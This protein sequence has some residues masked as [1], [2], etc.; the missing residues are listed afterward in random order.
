MYLG[1]PLSLTD[2]H[3]LGQDIKANGVDRMFIKKFYGNK[4]HIYLFHL[5]IPFADMQTQL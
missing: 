2:C 1:K 4:L 3:V 5:L